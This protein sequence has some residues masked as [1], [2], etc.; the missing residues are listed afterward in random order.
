MNFKKV[1]PRSVPDRD[2]YYMGMAFWA[3]SK[4]KDPKTQVGAYIIG[5]NNRPL[6]LGYNGPPKQFVD[7]ALNWDRPSKYDYMDH[8]EENAI[9]YAQGD[10]IGATIYVTAKPCINCTRKIIKNGIKKIIY[11]Q[12]K[13]ID[14]GSMLAGGTD[15][16]ER[17]D[18]MCRLGAIT[19][20]A[21]AGNLNWMRDRI[22]WMESIGIFD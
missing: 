9:D 10:L 2:D 6:G 7:S 22:K 15:L 17:L 1:G 8:A 16:T 4:S 13:D 5:M 14:P 21:F 19:M 12:A 18:D 11:Y 3:A 20:T